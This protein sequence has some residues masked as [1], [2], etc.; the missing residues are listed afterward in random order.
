VIPPALLVAVNGF[1]VLVAL[2]ARISIWSGSAGD[3]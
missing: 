2:S 3:D 1:L